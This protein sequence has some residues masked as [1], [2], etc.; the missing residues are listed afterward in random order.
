[1]KRVYLIF[2]CLGVV[3]ASF[4]D[5]FRWPEPVQEMKPWVYNWWMGSAVDQEGIEYQ[6]REL[7]DKGFGGFHVIPIFDLFCSS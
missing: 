2:S 6:C 3:A 7:A 4:G 5:V 1:M